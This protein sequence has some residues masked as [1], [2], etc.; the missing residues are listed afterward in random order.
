MNGI[1][2]KSG[3]N[4]CEWN[5]KGKC[6]NKKITRA[7]ISKIFTRDYESQINCTLTILGV[8]NCS[9]YKIEN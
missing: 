9:E 2:I 7:K 8:N 1:E 5:I 6:T 4:N 3:V